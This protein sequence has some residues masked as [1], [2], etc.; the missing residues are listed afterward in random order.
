[1]IQV[2]FSPILMNNMLIFPI[3]VNLGSDQPQLIHGFFDLSRI[4][5][6]H[7]FLN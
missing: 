2:I 6:I 1:M 5:E 7:N 3:D 4:V